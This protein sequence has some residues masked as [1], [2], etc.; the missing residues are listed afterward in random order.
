[1]RAWLEAR[2]GRHA[3][4]DIVFYPARFDVPRGSIVP[5]GDTTK[6]CGV[7]RTDHTYLTS[8]TQHGVRGVPSELKVANCSIG[9]VA[10]YQAEL[11]CRRNNN[12]E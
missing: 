11:E 7:A 4:F 12:T 5:L 8:A 2:D 1:M 10:K 3:W 6:W 9:H